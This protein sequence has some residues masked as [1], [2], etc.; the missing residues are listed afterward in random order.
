MR[1]SLLT[2]SSTSDYVFVG[3]RHVDRWWGRGDFQRLFGADHPGIAVRC[4]AGTWQVFFA[5]I[6]SDRKDS[7]GRRIRFSILIEYEGD[8][9]SENLDMVLGLVQEWLNSPWA[10]DEAGGDIS[11]RLSAVFSEKTIESWF[12]GGDGS[13]AASDD[14]TLARDVSDKI[15]SIADLPHHDLLTVGVPF[16]R[17]VGGLANT[18]A[19]FAFLA[20]VEEL[21]RGGDNVR[22][23]AIVASLFGDR[24]ELREQLDRFDELNNG[25]LAILISDDQEAEELRPKAVGSGAP[26]NTGEDQK[27]ARWNVQQHL[28]WVLLIGVTL[29]LLLAFLTKRC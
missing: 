1:F 10:G 23:A 13:K 3:R 20:A 19:R 21:L 18:D 6:P 24:Q 4:E 14:A 8:D 9:S 22:G 15:H 12:A 5:G 2:R 27:D 28:P 7:H 29:I 25:S 16:K 26:S 11:K 17:W